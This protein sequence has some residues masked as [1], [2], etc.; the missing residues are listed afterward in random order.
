MIVTKY[1]FNSPISSKG[2]E[3]NC[4]TGGNQFKNLSEAEHFERWWHEARRN[5]PNDPQIETA[6]NQCSRN[7]RSDHNY[8]EIGGIHRSDDEVTN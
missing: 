7:Q 1:E 6:A 5:G 2:Y 8:Q 3:G 4:Q